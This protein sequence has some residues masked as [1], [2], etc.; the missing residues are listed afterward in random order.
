MERTWLRTE[1][2]L[3]IFSVP[4]LSLALK[5]HVTERVELILDGKRYTNVVCI[6]RY[7]DG[8][9]P[10]NRV[11]L[12]SI[13]RQVRASTSNWPSCNLFLYSNEKGWRRKAAPP[14]LVDVINFRF[15]F[16]FPVA[17]ARRNVEQDLDDPIF[18]TDV[19]HIVRNDP[20]YQ[21]DPIMIFENDW[22]ILHD[23]I[24]TFLYPSQFLLPTA[25]GSVE[26]GVD[27]QHVDQ[28]VEQFV[29]QQASQLVTQPVMD[30]LMDHAT[31]YPS[32]VLEDTT[33]DTEC[34]PER[35]MELEEEPSEEIGNVSQLPPIYSQ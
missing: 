11:I 14:K 13:S 1:P 20:A 6:C 7:L 9:S 35:L 19:N 21:F 12:N 25:T 24:I 3:V 26:E 5:F 34:P 31:Q 18:F 32:Q 8:V 16:L 15:D 17:L 30:Q 4:E 28:P 22:K 23:F 33:S 29:G 27:E 2:G 10:S